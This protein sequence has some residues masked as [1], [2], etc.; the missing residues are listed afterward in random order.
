[1]QRKGKDMK[2]AAEAMGSIKKYTLAFIRWVVVAGVT[3]AVCGVLG[4]VFYKAVDWATAV[5]TA[6]SYIIGL[7]PLAGLLI[8]WMY[9]R[10]HMLENTGT[11]NVISSIRTNEE[12]PLALAPLIFIGTVLTHLFGGSAGREG[13]ALQLGGSV[14]YRV[15]RLFRLP[16]KDKNLVVMCGMAG[17]FSALFGTPLTATIFSMEVISVGVF[18]YA[19]FLPCLTSS[20]IAYGIAVLA[21]AAP[22][23]FVLSGIPQLSAAAFLQVGALS[24]LCALVSILF[25][26]AMHYFTHLAKQHIPNHYIRIFAG[27]MFIVL[28]TILLGTEYNGAGMDTIKRAVSGGDVAGYAFLLKIVFTVVTIGVGYR[29]GEIVPT[30][31]IGAAFGIAAGGLLGLDPGFAAALGMVALFC[32]VVNC[33]IASL[34]LAIEVFGAQGLLFFAAACSISY[35]LSGYYGL[36]SS[37]KIVYSKIRAEYINRSAE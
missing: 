18:H 31:F 17:L 6:N 13:A 28:L 14:G 29:G 2:T 21:G 19:G 11:N 3:G 1:M 23:R 15:G 7:L 16:E 8:V 33:P 34:M 30:F 32:G 26:I 24:A 12:V 22:V 4:A 35:M 9:K 27:G 25:C 5:R 20:V 36:Y 37:Q 10:F